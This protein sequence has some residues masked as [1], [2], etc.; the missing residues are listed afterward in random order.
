[1]RTFWL[2][3][4]VIYVVIQVYYGITN[5]SKISTQTESLTHTLINIDSI[6]TIKNNAISIT[7]PY[8]I[9][10]DKQNNNYNITG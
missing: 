1:M 10:L 5:A 3:Y 7:R 2:I 4:I 9:M 8:R 6:V